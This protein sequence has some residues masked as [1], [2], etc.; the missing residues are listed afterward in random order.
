[1]QLAR[2]RVEDDADFIERVWLRIQAGTG[3]V[4]VVAGRNA[5]PPAPF[6][7]QE[8]PPFRHCGSIG[9]S[10]EGNLKPQ[11][12][13]AVPAHVGV[14]P[15]IRKLRSQWLNGEGRH[16]L[17]GWNH[18]PRLRGQCQ[19]SRPRSGAQSAALTPAGPRLCC[20]PGMSVGF[21]LHTQTKSVT[22]FMF[23]GRPLLCGLLD[24]VRN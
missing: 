18:K 9:P 17:D 1:M 11:T 13:R 14:S 2:V 19:G 6:L 8:R 10:A 24:G 5:P 3:P 23:E 20:Y 12:R 22:D 16:S 4:A 21:G 15:A 7:N